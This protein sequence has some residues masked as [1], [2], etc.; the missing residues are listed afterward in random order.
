MFKRRLK[1]RRRKRGEGSESDS[2]GGEHD[3]EGSEAGQSPRPRPEAEGMAES[4]RSGKNDGDDE[5]V[6][7]GDPPTSAPSIAPGDDGKLNG[8]RT[9]CFWL[10]QFSPFLQLTQSLL[11]FL[12]LA[13][14][15]FI[16]VRANRTP[17][18][19]KNQT[20]N[21]LH[22]PRRNCYSG[23]LE[24]PQMPLV[25]SSPSPGVS[26]LFWKIARCGLP[27]TCTV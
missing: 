10:P 7:R 22:L 12:I 1:E 9:M 17:Q 5:E 25:H 3:T 26:V 18:T 19:I 15:S 4:G 13:R 27:A 11:P 16:S 6:V 23:G 21:R 24:I 14:K 8:T 20:G 2:R